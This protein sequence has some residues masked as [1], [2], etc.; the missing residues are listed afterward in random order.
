MADNRELQTILNSGGINSVYLGGTSSV[1]K[2]QK[3]SDM[4]GSNVSFDDTDLGIAASTV[5]EGI[6]ALGEVG[7]MVMSGT[8]L[9]PQTI[10]T[11]ATK[12]V[13]YDTKI[14]EAGVGVTGDVVNSKATLTLDRVFKIRFAAF[15]SYASNIDITWTIYKNGS[16]TG[17]AIT[18]S[19]QGATVFQIILPLQMERLKLQSLANK[20]CYNIEPTALIC[21]VIY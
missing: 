14:V 18:L 16:P 17:N 13:L 2:V 9:D 19:G 8:N 15:V 10:G 3:K 4:L 7:M 5:Q 1:H 20:L 6:A 21:G 12:V 11:S